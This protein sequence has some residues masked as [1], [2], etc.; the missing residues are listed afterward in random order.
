MSD[1]QKAKV[2]GFWLIALLWSIS[3]VAFI[4]ARVNIAF[5]GRGD[6]GDPVPPWGPQDYLELASVLGYIAGIATLLWILQFCQKTYSLFQILNE[7]IKTLRSHQTQAEA[8]LTQISENIL[9]SDAVK[10]VAFRDK[11]RQVLEEAIHQEIRQ[12][13]WVLA[14]KLIE[15]L[16]KDFGC[17]AEARQLRSE[18]ERFRKASI[19][20][21]ID[22]AVRHIE[23]LWLI[24][25]YSQAQ[26]EVDALTRLYPDHAKV[27]NL[28]GQTEKHRLAHKQTLMDRWSAAVANKRVEEAIEVLQLLDTY[29]T[30]DEAGALEETAREMFRMRLHQLGESFRQQ[31]QAKQWLEALRVG[32]VII[33]EFPNSRMAQ[34][35]QEK[36]DALKK[37]AVEAQ[38][39][40]SPAGS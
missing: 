39:K 40:K 19:Q 8:V 32:Q 31:V 38:E 13:K 33:R 2:G 34:E 35:V 17:V 15:D 20:D 36:L 28:D 5:E 6:S 27:Q 12:E 1:K 25:H 24:H 21:K 10:S 26:A 11:D 37:R 16:E 29:L 9:L 4:W 7:Q 3:L 22:N 18:V 14:E 30:Q 23:S